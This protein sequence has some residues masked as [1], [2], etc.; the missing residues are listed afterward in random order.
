MYVL[1]LYVW[2]Y[3]TWVSWTISVMFHQLWKILGLTF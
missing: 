2:N 1:Y 3:S